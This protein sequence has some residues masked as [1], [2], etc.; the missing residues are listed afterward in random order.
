MTFFQKTFYFLVK[1]F[2]FICLKVYNRLSIRWGT[3][4]PDRNVIVIANHCSNLDPVVM[5]AVFPRRVRF[6]GKSELFEPFL[7]GSMVRALGVVPVDKQDSQS[8]GTALK[9]FLRLLKEGENVLLF[10]EGGRSLDGKLKPL[11]GGA[12]LI[13]MKSGAPIVPAFVSGTFEAMPPGAKWVKP[14]HLAVVFGET[15]E[16]GE[17]M[18][19]G[20]EGRNKLVIKL[21]ETLES[22]ESLALELK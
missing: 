10:P 21:Q 3:S 19:L 22:L 4:L 11:E 14:V 6:L 7:F 12:A 15:I 17:Y 2:F 20:R 16:T 1:S 9:A 8:A 18:S 13:A 5:G